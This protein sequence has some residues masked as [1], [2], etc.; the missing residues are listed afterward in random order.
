MTFEYL[1]VAYHGSSLVSY[2]RIQ[3]HIGSF[4][5]A[6]FL[7]CIDDICVLAM[8]SIIIDSTQRFKHTA[9]ISGK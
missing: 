1:W 6:G 2:W 7:A 3:L 8:K 9:E 4:L 5:K